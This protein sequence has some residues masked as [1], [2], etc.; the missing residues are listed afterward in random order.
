MTRRSRF[1]PDSEQIKETMRRDSA[2]IQRLWAA[3]KARYDGD[4]EPPAAEE[5][6]T[7]AG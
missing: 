5:G 7:P 1:D 2:R 4:D 6:A 3:A